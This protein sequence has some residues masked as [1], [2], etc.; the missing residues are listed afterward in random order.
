MYYLYRILYKYLYHLI[1]IGSSSHIFIALSIPQQSM[2]GL[3]W[4]IHFKRRSF[5]LSHRCSYL[6]R[7]FDKLLCNLSTPTNIGTVN[8]MHWPDCMT[9]FWNKTLVHATIKYR[10]TI[11]FLWS[12]VLMV[13]QQF[14]MWFTTCILYN[15]PHI[16]LCPLLTQRRAQKNQSSN[17]KIK[18]NNDEQNF[19]GKSQKIPFQIDSKYHVWR[20]FLVP[21]ISYSFSGLLDFELPVPYCNIGHPWL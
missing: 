2:N 9:Q 21:K 20:T 10:L 12:Q 7:L 1:Q 3:I 4:N 13:W 18:L 17:T 5:R 6:D 14:L 15:P 8:T 11:R 16:T 19:Q